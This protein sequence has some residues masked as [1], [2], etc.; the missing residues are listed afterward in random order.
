MNSST[1]NSRKRV[2]ALIP[3]RG[4]SKGLPRKNIL[5]ADGRPLISWTIAAAKNSAVIDRI[6]LS[7]ED[8]E[9]I[10]IAK[11]LGCEVPFRR[12]QE[13]AD[14]K[15]SPVDVAIH[16]L[17]ALPGYDYLIL[18]QPTS[19]LRLSADIDAAFSL[20]NK[21][22][23]TSCV[24]VC[25]VDQHPYWMYKLDDNDQ[26]SRLFPSYTEIGRRQDLPPVYVLNGAIYIVRVDQFLQS[27]RFIQDD[28]VA[29]KM[30]S[31]RSIDIDNLHDFEFFLRHAGGENEGPTN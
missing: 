28:T 30:P 27:L 8:D 15:S 26:L 14:D 11:T 29:Y 21:R 9:I 5:I 31:E 3:A 19:P 17:K 12:P 4:G 7:S 13:L 22:G 24:S 10:N 23:A 18:L 1:I 6:V 20:M 2:L 25:E 16:A